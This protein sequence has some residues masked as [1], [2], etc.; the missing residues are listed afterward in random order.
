MIGFNWMTETRSNA[1][2]SFDHSL[3]YDRVE[4]QES[5]PSFAAAGRLIR[6][7]LCDA[8]PAVAPMTAHRREPEAPSVLVP[9]P[10]FAGLTKQEAESESLRRAL[11]DGRDSSEHAID[12]VV[13]RLLEELSW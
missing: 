9:P 8:I 10:P 13:E 12:F 7:R 5:V 4:A 3:V 11:A 2:I 6:G 1:P